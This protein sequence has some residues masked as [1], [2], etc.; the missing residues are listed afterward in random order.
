VAPYSK[1]ASSMRAGRCVAAIAGAASITFPNLGYR[2][3]P[4]LMLSPDGCVRPLDEGAAGT[5]FGDAVGALLLRGVGQAMASRDHIWA[6][7]RG[8]VWCLDAYHLT[9]TT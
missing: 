8:T 9:L 6:I 1:A 4:A 5:V 3:D 2:F 7:V